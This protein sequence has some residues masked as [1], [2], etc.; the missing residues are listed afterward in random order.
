MVRL[1][2]ALDVQQTV[3]VPQLGL[4]QRAAGHLRGLAVTNKEVAGGRR[5]ARETL[6]ARLSLGT[7]RTCNTAA[8]MLPSC[9]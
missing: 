2:I 8:T 3:A 9:G 5:G 4:P 7:R 6:G 1:L